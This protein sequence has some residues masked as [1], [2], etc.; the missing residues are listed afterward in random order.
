MDPRSAEMI[1]SIADGPA[2][3]AI[4]SDPTQYAFPVYTATP[5]TP[6]WQIPCVKYKCTLTSRQSQRRVSVLDG[7]PIP[8]GARPSAGSDGSM[9]VLDPATGT[10]WDLWQAKQGTD[11]SW[12]AS[13]GSVYNVAW[14]GAP[15]EYGS[16]GA[17]VP[18]LAGLVR[19]SEIAQD[20]LEHA[21]A[22]AYANVSAAGCVWPASKTDGKSTRANA[23]PEGARLQ[24]DPSLTD[25]DFAEMG[26]DRTGRIIAHTL[27]RYG[28]ILID[29]S[30][31]P[32]I[33]AEDLTANTL[34]GESWSDPDTLL[35]EDTIAAIPL[36][37]F[38][39]L[40]L[41]DGWEDGTSN[42]RHG[43]CAR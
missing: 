4:F 38:R 37:E 26:L 5:D 27:Q 11:G 10:E 7:V 33:V 24:L 25:A 8:S 22:F 43:D 6:R 19:H 18:Y 28:M 35:T 32:K 34:T 39:V 42:R 30:G 40:R 3:D 41:P 36:E 16:R 9:V 17:G 13:N 21:I 2:D 23:L 1:Q 20:R 29:V 31:R 14:D 12:T 15:V